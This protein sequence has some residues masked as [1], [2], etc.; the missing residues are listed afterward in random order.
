MEEKILKDERSLVEKALDDRVTKSILFDIFTIVDSVTLLT[1][2][3]SVGPQEVLLM[4]AHELEEMTKQD[5][6]RVGAEEKA[7]LLA[8]STY[9]QSK[10]KKAFKLMK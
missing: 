2:R 8:A 5:S 4:A 3:A 7:F 6:K 10:A 9:L 1:G